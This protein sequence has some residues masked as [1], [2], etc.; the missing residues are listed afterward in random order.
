LLGQ[1]GFSYS[2]NDTLTIIKNTSASAVLGQFGSGAVTLNGQNFTIDTANGANNVALV[3]TATTWI[4]DGG[5]A[6]DNWTTAG[7][8]T[9]NLNSPGNGDILHFAGILRLTPN[10]DNASLQLSQILFDSGAG[11]FVLGGNG[12]T[13]TA[14]IANNSSTLQTVNMP[15]TLAGNQSFNATVGQ[16]AFGVAASINGAATLTLN[17]PNQI[18]FSAALGRLVPLT[19]ISATAPV[20]FNVPG[21]TSLNPTVTT[22]G[23]QNYGGQVTLAKG[24]VLVA[25]NAV[26]P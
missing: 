26:T 18:T 3:R 4:W 1:V 16:L 6:N 9:A 17:G 22:T 14:G 19:G 7:N 2:V 13:L 15:L 12:V 5:G 20:A 25:A 21:S 10:N 23:D 24:A 8:W 11:A